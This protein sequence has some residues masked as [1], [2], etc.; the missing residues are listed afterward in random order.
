MHTDTDTATL[1]KRVRTYHRDLDTVMEQRLSALLR[2]YVNDRK[3]DRR[4][5]N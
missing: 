2:R 1:E 4:P 3:E 5:R